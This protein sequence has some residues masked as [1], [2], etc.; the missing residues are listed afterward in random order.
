MEI[1]TNRELYAHLTAIGPTSRDLET[2][3]R[4]LLRVGRESGPD[5]PSAHAVAMMFT[6][7]VTAPPA[8]DEPTWSSQRPAWQEPRPQGKARFEAILIDQ[9]V[10]LQRMRANGQ[11]ADDHRYFGLDAPSGAR[12]Y[13]FDPASY[14]EGGASGTIGG[15]ASDDE[16]VLV[17]PPADIP[18]DDETR[19]SFGWEGLCDLLVCGQCYE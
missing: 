17:T 14:L 8:E 9:I 6:A 2:F 5:E 1:R 12:W 19:R 3:L 11:L 7:A 13:N 15:W 4:A 10:D 16:V 18:E